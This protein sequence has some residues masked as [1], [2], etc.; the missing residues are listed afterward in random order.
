M[1]AATRPEEMGKIG[2]SRKDCIQESVDAGRGRVGRPGGRGGIH[3]IVGRFGGMVVR[4]I[5]RMEKGG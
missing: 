4:W 3:G 2:E 5:G 1:A